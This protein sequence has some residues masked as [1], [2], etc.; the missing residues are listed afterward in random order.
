MGEMAAKLHQ[1]GEPG[2]GSNQFSLEV[3][4]G[5][6]FVGVRENCA[7]LDEKID[8]FDQCDADTWSPLWIKDFV[9]ELGY[10]KESHTLKVHWL[11][12]GKTI[13]DGLRLIET[14]SDTMVMILPKV[15]SPV[16]VVT[17]ERKEVEKLPVFYTNLRKAT[18]W[19]QDLVHDG[20]E[21]DDSN[22]DDSDFNDSDYEIGFFYDDLF[23]NNVDAGVFDEGATK[24]CKM[25]KWKK[26]MDNKLKRKQSMTMLEDLLNPSFSVG[27]VFGTV[28]LVRKAIIEYSLR[29]RV[30]IKMPRNDRKRVK[31]H[32]AKG[33]P[34]NIYASMDSR[35]NCFLVKTYNGHH[36]CQKKWMIKTCTSK[37]LVEKYLETFRADNKMTLPNFARTIQKEWNLTPSRTKLWRAR[38]FALQSIYGDELK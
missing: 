11:L 22:L 30:E 13:T 4:H 10:D 36:N 18:E 33:C 17:T 38:K 34:W 8:W 27:Q 35:T 24:G 3:H 15:F 7:Y 28:E 12:P 5:G 29:N 16:K 37:W 14:D 31:A 2:L 32:C 21:A 1:K 20:I 25:F 26:A 6:F 9:E 19:N 23:A